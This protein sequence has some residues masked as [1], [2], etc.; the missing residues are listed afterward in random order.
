LQPINQW[1]SDFLCNRT[2]SECNVAYSYLLSCRKS[3]NISARVQINVFNSCN[4]H[5]TRLRKALGFCTVCCGL[6]RQYSQE[7]VY[8]VYIICMHRQQ[9]MFMLNL[10]LYSKKCST[11]VWVVIIDDYIIGPYVIFVLCILLCVSMCNI[12][13]LWRWFNPT[14]LH[15]DHMC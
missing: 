6:M 11:S 10:T 2:F 13:G 9:K 4:G 14:I 5:C 7:M 8:T 3:T 15:I 12:F 1:L